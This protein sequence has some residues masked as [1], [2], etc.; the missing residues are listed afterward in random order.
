M[1]LGQRERFNMST[2][3]LSRQV[4]YGKNG[5]VCTNSPLSAAAGLKALQDGGN[6]FDAA[7]A[8][9]ATETVL[10]PS[11]ELNV[12]SVATKRMIRSV[13]SGFWLELS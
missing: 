2:G 9:A 7:L 10:S 13:S 6:A 12:P 11:L 3:R 1:I 5:M 4:V 8:V